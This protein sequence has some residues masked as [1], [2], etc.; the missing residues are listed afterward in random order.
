[1]A[2]TSRVRASSYFPVKIPVYTLSGGVGRQIPSKRLPS[3]VYD[4]VNFFCTP[5]ASLE[6]RNGI[7]Y[8]SSL[9]GISDSVWQDSPLDSDI[10]PDNICYHWMSVGNDIAILTI[11]NTG[12]SWVE[13][14]GT[15][16]LLF[17]YKIGIS[18]NSLSAFQ[19]DP[20]GDGDDIN[21]GISE[22]IFKYITH[23]D[24][25]TK[26]K[27]RLE[28]INIGSS[29]LVL[30]K[31]VYAGFT[32]RLKGDST[33][34]L[35]DLYG[36]EIEGEEDIKGANISYL[37]STSVDPTGKA[38]IWTRSQDYTW[39][40]YV[41]DTSDPVYDVDN[42]YTET[43]PFGEFTGTI[44]D[45]GRVSV[46]YAR[47]SL[48]FVKSVEERGVFENRA[49]GQQLQITGIDPSGTHVTK[50]Y[51]WT[52][53]DGN[54]G[55]GDSLPDALTQATHDFTRDD[56]Y[57]A[58]TP[59]GPVLPVTLQV[60]KS[61]HATNMSQGSAGTYTTE[62]LGNGY[63]DAQ[64]LAIAIG[65]RR[66]VLTSTAISSSWL[67]GYTITS[68]D[69]S[70]VIAGRKT[71]DDNVYHLWVINETGTFPVS[72]L[73][74]NFTITAPDGS[75]LTVDSSNSGSTSGHGSGI[76]DACFE[77]YPNVRSE[78][79]STAYPGRITI[80][81]RQGGVI[82][83]TSIT[84]NIN[85]DS[86]PV[87][88]WSLNLSLKNSLPSKFMD[89]VETD[90]ESM[91]DTFSPT[92]DGTAG[93][94]DHWMEGGDQGPSTTPNRLRFGIWRVKSFL[95]TDELPGPTNVLLGDD[96]DDDD[97]GSQLRPHEDLLRWER[98]PYEDSDLEDAIDGRLNVLTSKFIPVEDF[99]YPNST[100]PELGQSVTK[101]SDL[102]FPPDTSDMLAFNGVELGVSGVGTQNNMLSRLYPE[103]DVTVDGVK[104]YGKGKIYH[105]SEAYLSNTPGWYRVVSKEA[106]Y[107]KKVRTPG[108]RAVIDS[109]RMPKMIYSYVE[110]GEVIYTIRN[111]AWDP[112]ESGDEDSN[113]GPGIFFDPASGDPIE[114]KIKT[115]AFY[116]DRLFFANDDTIIASRTADWDNFF[117]A[118]P[119]LIT[120][121]DPIDLM[122]SS[123]N[124][125][126][127]RSLI[128]F[129]DFLFVGTDGNTQYEMIGS[130]NILSP[131][132]AEFAP[133][134]FYPMMPDV[135]PITMNNNLF[136]FSKEKLYIYFGQR[137]L[138]TEQAFEVSRHIPKYLPN[139]IT[140][141]TSSSFSS[142]IFASSENKIYCYRNQM[143]GEQVIQNAFFRFDLA[144]EA[145]YNNLGSTETVANPDSLFSAERYLYI[146]G[147][148]RDYWQPD[149]GD[150]SD[151]IAA[152][153]M[154]IFFVGRL[155]LEA[156]YP[157]VP[158]LD[159][160]RKFPSSPDITTEYDEI[161]N[162]TKITLNDESMQNSPGFDTFVTSEG[163][164]LSVKR[165][166]T[167]DA[168]GSV[169]RLEGSYSIDPLD[170]LVYAGVNFKSSVTLSPIYVRDEGNNVTPGTLNLRY[171]VINTFNSKE[172]DVRVQVK[173]R[174]RLIHIGGE[175]IIEQSD[176]WIGKDSYSGETIDNSARFPIL[177]YTEDTE[178]T[179]ES[180]NP[181]PLNIASLQFTGK[182]KPVSR[183]HNS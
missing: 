132:T 81:Q 83:N 146:V 65:G 60:T 137:D 138:A 52:N 40:D 155:Y 100:T 145:A 67:N 64:E 108:K 18:D 46:P 98:V 80:R 61:V 166:F 36:N 76:S 140:A 88:N 6:K 38:E 162:F 77:L 27:D 124:Y 179:I 9:S 33:E 142:S 66:L 21:K 121:T 161:N 56:D 101:L 39:D 70:A 151:P 15:S 78:V 130:N 2:K 51:L 117:M 176:D 182:F 42:A 35:K 25:T 104:Y 91:F 123:N 139:S 143:S 85:V 171:G 106:P 172:F 73:T 157:T 160:W 112:R 136:F 128:P 127:I 164:V 122:V 63:A 69:W 114:T 57:G 75:T 16:D 118:N 11:V 158:R 97:R 82:G 90:T 59:T 47:L 154:D 45:E 115:M 37:T 1:M 28:I 89:G 163:N 96:N 29:T 86:S 141:A 116:R 32:T 119:E 129:R 159:W 71:S 92:W 34:Y 84:Q 12:A 49:Q 150:G 177:G 135:K 22:S 44:W 79:S 107:I 105:L 147:N 153:W 72:T 7:E 178:I 23:V 55:G 120:D 175:S 133:T 134:A 149:P 50:T 95:G 125:T 170:N 24:G 156:E 17:V 174:D 74:D 103:D 102:K 165:L 10:D 181:N 31:D 14:E 168:P 110:G 53:A 13:N 180:N 126:P 41:I 87:F 62:E 99:V 68:G 58:V 93:I 43:Y 131:L 48:D 5:Q 167:P 4:M 113:R 94:A 148:K 3:E 26:A 173:G 54:S 169:Y 109:N 144:H 183:D 111:V 19:I 20:Y 8:I 30:N 152:K